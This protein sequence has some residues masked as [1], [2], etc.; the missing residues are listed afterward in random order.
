MR[1]EPKPTRAERTAQTRKRMLDAA[2]Q[3]FAESG[4]HGAL[5]AEIARNAGVAEPTLY[6]TFHS[7]AELLQ[8]VLAHAGAAQ[9]EPATVE[10]R[11][12]FATVLEEPNPRRLIALVV[13]NGTDILKRLAPLAETMSAAS[14]SDPAAAAVIAEISSRRRAGF[15]RMVAAAGDHT[16]LGMPA[17]RAVDV[18]DVVQSAAT[19]NA[20]VARGWTVTQFKAWSYG[21]LSQQL[22]PLPT[23]TETGAADAIAVNGLTF[24]SL[25]QRDG[26]PAAS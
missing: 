15:A 22:L 12:W 6:F 5:M 16:T 9:S 20:F 4:Y 19:F 3:T 11:P 21:I 1:T 17:E 7:K 23:L 24:E 2:F 18:I 8:Q 13:E 25:I 14:A 10:Q 26:G